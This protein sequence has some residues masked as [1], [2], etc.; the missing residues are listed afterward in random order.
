[1]IGPNSSDAELAIPQ[2]GRLKFDSL[3]RTIWIELSGGSLTMKRPNTLA[4]VQLNMVC[5]G[6]VRSL[7]TRKQTY[8][9]HFKFCR[10]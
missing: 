9:A 10:S 4:V 8:Y 6:A 2:L 5:Q 1:M 7:S 3:N